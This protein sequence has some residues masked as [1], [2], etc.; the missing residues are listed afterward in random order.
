[1]KHMMY[2]ATVS[3]GLVASAF[4]S[5]YAMESNLFY[6]VQFEQFEYRLGDENEKRAVWDGD[7]FV[8]TD[9]LKLRLLSE[10]E[11]DLDADSFETLENRLVL[12]T[13]ISDF[14][15]ARAGVRLDSP[16]GTD[17]WYGTAG[18]FG[19]APQW[20]EVGADFFVS[21]TGD[22][23]A[24]LD[25][26]YEGLLTNDIT[27]T[28]SMELD[29]AFSDD[30]EIEIGSGL[31]KVELGLRLS[32]DLIDRAVVPYIGV[33]YERKLGNTADFARADN[34]DISTTYFVIGMRLMY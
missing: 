12:Q 34:E 26:G 8:G 23:S 5:A 1:M 33:S 7:L 10:G 31:S 14:F 13:P 24:R 19:L 21:E 32:Y 6:G 18:V 15:D 25:V 4:T 9:A 11:R 27:L 29:M 20:F 30:P 16:T 2:L 17:R 22:G 3:I 28:P